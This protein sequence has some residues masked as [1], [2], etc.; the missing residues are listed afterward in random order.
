M[1]QLKPVPVAITALLS[2]LLIGG[3]A[4][5]AQDNKTTTT[6]I[7]TGVKLSGTVIDG[8]L[9]GAVVYADTNL[10]NRLNAWEPWAV[11][12]SEGYFSY[13]PNT[14][15]DYCSS[16]NSADQ[17][18]C[19]KG[20]LPAEGTIRLNFVGGYDLTTSEPFLGTLAVEIDASKLASGLTM[21]DLVASPL[22]TI[23]TLSSSTTSQLLNAL[24]LSGKDLRF[25]FMDMNKL[26]GDS[27]LTDLLKRAHQLQK[28][29]EVIAPQIHDALKELKTTL[30]EGE[31]PS[32]ASRFVYQAIANWLKNNKIADLNKSAI[33]SIIAE[34]LA[35]AK[36]GYSVTEEPT[37]NNAGNIASSADEVSQTTVTLYADIQSGGALGTLEQQ[38]YARAKLLQAVTDYAREQP[39]QITTLQTKATNIQTLLSTNPAILQKLATPN[40]DINLIQQDLVKPDINTVINDIN[41]QSDN[42]ATL[43][44]I[45]R[46][47]LIGSVKTMRGDPLVKDSKTYQRK[48]AIFFGA[49][50]TLTACVTY[51]QDKDPNILNKRYTGTWRNLNDYTVLARMTVGGAEQSAF[52]RSSRNESCT[53]P[54][55]AGEEVC[56]AFEF[57]KKLEYWP[58]GNLSG[59]AIPA[60]DDDCK[61]ILDQIVDPSTNP[62]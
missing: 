20:N 46:D 17:R 25:N 2:T 38:I 3:C 60:S 47:Q 57:N 1:L 11:T 28:I 62:S 41:T 36:Q 37:W 52:F 45:K 53:K 59:A 18:H 15:V 12:D 8:Y 55:P 43:P 56:Y 14:G 30:K 32:D 61:V 35:A 22:T 27:T 39:D 21:A 4:P 24:G 40:Y 50:D 58:T 13:N 9:A 7:A 42:L 54:V 10:N 33:E 29:V 34:A 5:D 49:N 26:A 23:E 51:E 6:N 19:L 31:K 16:G 48:A 44:T